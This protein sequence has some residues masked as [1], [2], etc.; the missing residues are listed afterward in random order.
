[1][2]DRGAGYVH[3]DTD[4]I[5]EESGVGLKGRVTDVD[6][7]SEPNPVAIDSRDAVF[8]G[9]SVESFHCH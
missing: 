7:S 4:E 8:G 1:M 3:E 9:N 6:N 5:G 2:L